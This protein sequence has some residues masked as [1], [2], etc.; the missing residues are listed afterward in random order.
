MT[1]FFLLCSAGCF[2]SFDIRVTAGEYTRFT[3]V[4]K[5][6][7]ISSFRRGFL[8]GNWLSIARS[9]K[10]GWDIKDEDELF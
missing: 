4:V 10:Y 1:T 3:L 8:A 6:N 2:L 5:E 7:I 9:H